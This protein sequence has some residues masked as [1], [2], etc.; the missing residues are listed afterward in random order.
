VLWAFVGVNTQVEKCVSASHGHKHECAIARCCV[1]CVCV[2]VLV[3]MVWTER[4]SMCKRIFTQNESET[5][6][7]A[8]KREI[9]NLFL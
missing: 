6:W 3:R 8:C 7:S 1:V 9:E 5:K 4:E 2:F